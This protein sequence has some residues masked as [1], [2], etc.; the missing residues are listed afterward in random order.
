MLLGG[1]AWKLAVVVAA[2]LSG[3]GSASLVARLTTALTLDA[4]V[5]AVALWL[6]TRLPRL[7]PV[8]VFVGVLGGLNVYFA[9]VLGGPVTRHLLPFASSVR[10]SMI[11]PLPALATVC[12]VIAVVGGARRLGRLPRQT[13]LRLLV[14]AF[15]VGL[16]GQAVERVAGTAAARARPGLDRHHLFVLWS[17][18]DH[19]D[20]QHGAVDA[21]LDVDPETAS[22]AAP[23]TRASASAPP[24]HVVLVVLESMATRHIDDTTMPFL[25]AFGADRAV[26]FDDHTAE[27]PVSI[28]ALFSLLCGLPPLPESELESEAIPRIDCQ[29]LPEVLA[30]RGFTAGFF[31][32]GYFAFTDKLAF[33]NER[34]FSTLVDGENLPARTPVWKNGWGT[35]DRVVV[36]EALRWLDGRLEAR[37]QT[38]SVVVPLIPHYEYFLPE[39]AARPFGTRTLL[40]RYKN[41]LRF[42]DDVLRRL[43]E[44]YRARGVFDETV[45]VVVGDHGEAFD[46]HAGNRLHGSYL[47][48]ENLRAPLTIRA[49]SLPAGQQR[50]RR[51]ST[52]ADISPTILGL[53]GVPPPTRPG[54]LDELAGLD[55]LSPTY[56][57]SPS[58][59]F[60]S[61]PEPRVAIRAATKKLIV[62]RSTDTTE[63]Y[64][65]ASDSAERAPLIDDRVTASLRV[66]GESTLA[67]RRHLLRGAPSL[68]PSYLQR[69]AS[70]SSLPLLSTRVFNM[71]RPCIPLSTA[72]DAKTILRLTGLSPP[73]RFVGVGVVDESRHRREGGLSVRITA[74]GAATDVVVDDRFESS[75]AVVPVPPSTDLTITASPSPRAARGCVWLIP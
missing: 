34:G 54:G 27:A 10:L 39:D 51:P 46:E 55:L 5:A 8:A 41:G 49:S 20:L 36:D 37:E 29:S 68:G 19:I 33:L 2:I 11:A 53:L 62:N 21:V 48:E 28:K 17:R 44:G 74:G 38:L 14:A 70:S 30:A 31:H 64:D 9:A 13:F 66:F 15:V 42:A 71:V 57:P 40:D 16:A 43:I 61:Y 45:F 6:G 26:V 52:H 23:I 59:H 67:R 18:Q 32:G 22:R 3:A 50:S 58:V 63:L 56:L 24:R 35:D 47:Y 4:V 72:P 65:R 73:A 25:T 7:V 75:S 69:A 1:T 12:A 60:T